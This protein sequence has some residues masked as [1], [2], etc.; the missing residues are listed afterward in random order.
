MYKFA[1]LAALGLASVSAVKAESYGDLIV[2]FTTG[3]GSD[4]IYDLGNLSTLTSGETWSASTLGISGGT[5]S[6][7]VIGDGSSAYQGTSYDTLYTTLAAGLPFRLNGNGAWQAPDTGINTLVAQLP[8]GAA[9]F[10]PNSGTT[11]ATTV[12]GNPN[13]NSWLAETVNGSLSTAFHNAYVNPNVANQA[14]A[15]LYQVN[16][17]N[18]APTIDGTFSLSSG[19]T[20]TFNT[21]SAVPEPATYG[22][23][24]GAGMLLLGLRRQFSRKA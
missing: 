15:D 8:G 14:V 7:G 3:S 23:L 9:N 4:V 2:G 17:D 19:G 12:A 24:S 6:W 21:V 13:P 11:I 5:Y 22:L 16:D 20:L 1:L 18:S 10:G